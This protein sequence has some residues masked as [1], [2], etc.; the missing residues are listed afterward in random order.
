VPRLK[1][2]VQLQKGMCQQIFARHDVPLTRAA[3]AH[4]CGAS[5]L[6]LVAC[7]YA[8]GRFDGLLARFVGRSFRDGATMLLL[9][10]LT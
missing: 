10:T 1:C 9:I 5:L 4:L 7:T 3:E 2:Q 6:V 8:F